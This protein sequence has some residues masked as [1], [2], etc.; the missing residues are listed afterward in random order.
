MRQDHRYHH[1]IMTEEICDHVPPHAKHILDGTL[2]HGGHTV[3]LHDH[4]CQESV[5]TVD[6]VGID[7]DEK[8]LEIAEKRL[9]TYNH[10]IT[11][12]AAYDQWEEIKK[13][14]GQTYFDYIL[15][16]IGINR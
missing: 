14:A 9:S 1:T 3:A 8:M 7:K 5:N 12:H 6:V 15:L 10:I 13:I 2:G 4:C 11:G 16:D